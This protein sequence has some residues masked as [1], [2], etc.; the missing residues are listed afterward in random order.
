MQITLK[1]G[2][3]FTMS[4]SDGA[5]HPGQTGGQRTGLNVPWIRL[6]DRWYRWDGGSTNLLLELVGCVAD[7]TRDEVLALLDE[8][9]PFDGGLTVREQRFLEWAQA[10]PL[11]APL[12][13]REQ[14]R[15]T[16]GSL[17]IE[18]VWG[19]WE[20]DRVLLLTLG[21]PLGYLGVFKGN[22][23]R[24]YGEADSSFATAVDQLLLS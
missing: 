10:P 22:G 8:L 19:W 12:G 2:S 21:E 15:G 16:V 17:T 23:D 14:L 11:R 3:T 13:N 9:R 6:D 4:S 7:F 1:D 24:V 20:N 18:R 5:H